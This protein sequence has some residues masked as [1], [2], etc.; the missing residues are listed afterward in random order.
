ML[1]KCK[2]LQRWRTR[3]GDRLSVETFLII[4]D[5]LLKKLWFG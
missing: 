1:P 5:R 2:A 4:L 3:Y